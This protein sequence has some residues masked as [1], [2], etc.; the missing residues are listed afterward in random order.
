MPA[1]AKTSLWVYQKV[2]D[3]IG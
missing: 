1:V 2:L 3:G